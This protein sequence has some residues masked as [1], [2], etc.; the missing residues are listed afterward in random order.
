MI[1]K[2]E[3]FRAFYED[4]AR[5]CAKPVD[6]YDEAEAHAGESIVMKGLAPLLPTKRTSAAGL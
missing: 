5:M 3:R 1:G 6:L 2:N 4:L